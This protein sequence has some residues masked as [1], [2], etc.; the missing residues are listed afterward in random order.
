MCLVTSA[1]TAKTIF[2]RAD[3]LGFANKYWHAVSDFEQ[4]PR[5]EI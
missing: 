2:E 4:N 1:A 3:T 5:I